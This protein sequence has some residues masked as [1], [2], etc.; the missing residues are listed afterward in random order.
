MSATQ[1]I[2]VGV[3]GAGENTAA[4]RFALE[5][6]RTSRLGVT[7]VHAV[8]PSVPPPPPT[9]L[10]TDDTWLDVGADIVE[11]VRREA[12]CLLREEGGRP[13]TVTTLVQAGS[14]SATMSELSRRSDLIV[15]QHRDLSR[16][17]RLV[18]G[19][20]VASVAAH[21]RCPVVSVPAAASRAAHGVVT[22]GVE[23]DG[24]PREVLEAAFA[25]ASAHGAALRLIYAWRM[26]SA[27]DEIFA[28]EAR[29]NRES[30]ALVHAAAAELQD[31]YP[32]VPVS[33]EVRHDAPADALADAAVTSDLLVV[34][35]HSGHLGLPARLGFLARAMVT[36]AQCPVLVVPL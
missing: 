15:L 19:S 20:T 8:N 16:V 25:R 14:A 3:T 22:A 29:W 5:E 36:H 17:H 26:A 2:L 33:V 23:Q 18:T 35:R 30:E 34:G 27:Y 24:S 32:E 11:G 28:E 1:P 10:I 21:A 13:V 4:L 7:L 9:V 12:Q 6:A 31:K